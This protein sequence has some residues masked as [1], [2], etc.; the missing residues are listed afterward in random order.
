MLGRDFRGGKYRFGFNR[1][2]DINELS[3]WQDYG[4]RM[5]MTR[6]GRFPNTDP[7]TAKFPM[8]SPFQFASLN[9]IAN[10]DLDGLEGMYYNIFTP[11]GITTA[12]A[13]QQEH[14]VKKFIIKAGR[15]SKDA[16]TV[17]GGGLGIASG[18]SL[19]A[20]FA[21]GAAIVGGGR[22][23]IWDA[24]GEYE[25]SDR[26]QTSI[27]GTIMESTNYIVGEEVFSQ[28]LQSTSSM[29]EGVALMDFNKLKSGNEVQK[30]NEAVGIVNFASDIKEVKP[31]LKYMLSTNYPT[32]SNQNN[33]S[34]PKDN[35]QVVPPVRP[36][37]PV[38][39]Y[40]QSKRTEQNKTKNKEE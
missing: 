14:D 22:K 34:V 8:L 37:L 40:Y 26:V 10:I 11:V 2:E 9:P 23:F 6:L 30:T 15:I 20:V 18:G 33:I 36:V 4:E 12:T 38:I 19:I 17:I 28:R 3:D 29:I 35:A 5:Y 13:Q 31:N 27:S 24:Q 25:K 16:S 32:I 39:K 1:K 21:G 7:L